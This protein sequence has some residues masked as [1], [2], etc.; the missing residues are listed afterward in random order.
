MKQKKGK[1][2]ADGEVEWVEVGGDR[3]EEYGEVGKRHSKGRRK[4]RG[5][6]I[7]V[8]VRPPPAEA[9]LAP[10][11][12]PAPSPGYEWGNAISVASYAAAVCHCL[13]LAPGRGTRRRFLCPERFRRFCVGGEGAEGYW[14][15]ISPPFRF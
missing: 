10:P 7:G 1:E 12:P 15:I 13:G 8:R 2:G 6:Y 4:G 9:S 11:P 5:D 14:L 3:G